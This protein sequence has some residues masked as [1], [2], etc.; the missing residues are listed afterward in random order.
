M[1]VKLDA[2]VQ[3][4]IAIVGQIVPPEISSLG[5]TAGEELPSF[6]LPFLLSFRIFTI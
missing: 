5:V 1:G 2:Q 6:Y 4:G 3:V